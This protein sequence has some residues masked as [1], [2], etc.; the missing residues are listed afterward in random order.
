MNDGTNG[1][2]R[3]GMFPLGSMRCSLCFQQTWDWCRAPVLTGRKSDY[4]LSTSLETTPQF[5][6]THRPARF[7]E[8]TPTTA[9]R[10]R[11]STRCDTLRPGGPRRRWASRGIRSTRFDVNRALAPVEQDGGRPPVKYTR[12]SASSSKPR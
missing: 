5:G 8:P 12:V 2:F 10:G 1:M 11:D 7:V 9:S 4:R 6:A 3:E